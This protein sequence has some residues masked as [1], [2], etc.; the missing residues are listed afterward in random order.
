MI[1]V[2]VSAVWT[3]SNTCVVDCVEQFSIDAG[4]AEIGRPIASQAGALAGRALSQTG[5]CVSTIRASTL[6]C[7]ISHP[8]GWLEVYVLGEVVI[9]AVTAEAVEGRT[10]VFGHAS[11]AGEGARCCEPHCAGIGV[12]D[13]SIG[14][15]C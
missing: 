12:D 11:L 7:S 4:A 3:T 14:V 2:L 13:E 5:V 6:A 10:R 8:W 9:L 1:G 15:E